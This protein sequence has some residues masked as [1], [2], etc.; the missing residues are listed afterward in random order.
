M[1]GNQSNLRQNFRFLSVVSVSAAPSPCV[2]GAASSEGPMEETRV[3]LCCGPGPWAAGGAG[4]LA[5]TPAGAP[6]PR[7]TSLL[8]T[9]PGC[10]LTSRRWAQLLLADLPGT[11]LGSHQCPA[12][13]PALQRRVQIHPHPSLP[14][15][16]A[17]ATKPLLAHKREESAGVSL[18]LLRIKLT[19]PAFPRAAT[20]LQELPCSQASGETDSVTRKW[21]TLQ[22]SRAANT[23]NYTLPFFSQLWGSAT[24]SPRPPLQVISII[25]TA[26]QGLE[27]KQA[28]AA[29]GHLPP[30]RQWDSGAV[31]TPL[32][33]RE[34][35]NGFPKD[36]QEPPHE[37]WEAN[38]RARNR[39]ITS[40]MFE[41]VQGTAMMK[42]ERQQIAAQM[43]A[44]QLWG[45][46]FLTD[47]ALPIFNIYNSLIIP[48][49][50]CTAEECHTHGTSMFF[51]NI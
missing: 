30:P 29:H 3:R 14:P 47:F 16:G 46:S 36:F 33:D 24:A 35:V 43:A 37:H 17:V 12:L 32:W 34:G 28:A 44:P 6:A 2:D 49:L 8:S 42:R 9:C 15:A 41:K 4:A 7:L 10:H 39:V 18:S 19:Y 21:Q 48:L 40:T 45:F 13:P 5:E 23:S 25:K 50:A 27:A 31:R 11:L 51:Q 22:P 20:S 26:L 38:T 1:D